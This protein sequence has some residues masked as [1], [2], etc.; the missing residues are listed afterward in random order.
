ME[1]LLHYVWQYKL[2]DNAEQTTTEG[3]VF[4]VLDS[5]LHNTDSGP[6]FFNAKLK[7]NEAVWVGNVEIHTYASDWYKHG[8]QTDKAYDSVILHVVE[9]ADAVVYRTNGEVI[10]QI[11][12]SIPDHVK[13]N[14]TTL[15][16]E[17]HGV[18]CIKHLDKLP[19]F[20][21]SAWMTVLL[22]E[23]L[24]R[25][26][27]DIFN[28]LKRNSNDW[29]ETFYIILCRS[30][31]VGINSD[32]FEYLAKSLPLRILLKHRDQPI[33]IEALLFGQAGL[34]NDT[35]SDEYYQRLQTEYQFLKHK[36]Q[37]KSVEGSLYKTMRIRP[38]NFPHIK[39]AQL[40]ALYIQCDTLFSRMIASRDATSLRN[41]FKITPS[42]YWNTHYH[43][44]CT[45][46]KSDKATGGNFLNIVLINTVAPLMY[47]YGI[48][49]DDEA[50][51]STAIELLENL[52]AEVNFITSMFK[53]A[54]CRLE[55]A[56]DSQA[57][58]Q[59]KR[60]YCEQKK[61]LYCRIGFRLLSEK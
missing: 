48:R 24:E 51:Q 53:K 37:L 41:L 47:A 30:F 45:S 44:R 18:S 19:P 52:P 46:T 28:H 34:L 32:A 12:L 14:Y 56:G 33:Q 3:G 60:M 25:K 31:G 59:L 27:N 2:Y 29:N 16:K 54:G 9:H 39:L 15:I 21:L 40:A 23:R 36:Y 6:D 10:P 13:Q 49:H 50:L 42:A 55:H 35:L 7:C 17:A 8:H 20:E 22:S 26:T 61:C 57:L 5:G 58:I 11:E 43:F 1:C 38:A 4:T